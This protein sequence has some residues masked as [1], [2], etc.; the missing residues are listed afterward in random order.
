MVRESV[1]TLKAMGVPDTKIRTE[2]WAR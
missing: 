1:F 2:L